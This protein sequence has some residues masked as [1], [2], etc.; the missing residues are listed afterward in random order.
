MVLVGVTFR[1]GK[2]TA[3]HSFL[4]ANG[5]LSWLEL[6]LERISARQ[7]SAKWI[8]GPCLEKSPG[9][10]IGSTGYSSAPGVT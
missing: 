2:R 9:S 10:Q 1:A 8:Y 7:R 6:L 4:L 3:A 5:Q